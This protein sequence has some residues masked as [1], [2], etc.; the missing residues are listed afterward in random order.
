[1]ANWESPMHVFGLCELE[2]PEK[3]GE[4]RDEANYKK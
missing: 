2:N 3:N 1:M 4:A